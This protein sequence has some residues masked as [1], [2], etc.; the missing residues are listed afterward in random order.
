MKPLRAG[1]GERKLASRQVGSQARGK[2]VTDG[3][4]A[5][6]RAPDVSWG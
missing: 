6:C 1:S 2:G 3:N 5:F 4:R